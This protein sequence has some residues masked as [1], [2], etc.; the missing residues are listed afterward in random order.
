M[1]YFDL[2]VKK[3]DEPIHL[4]VDSTGLKVAG[5]GEWK[6]RTWGAEY[7]RKWIKLHIGLDARSGQIVSAVVTDSKG[8][9][10]GPPSL[11]TASQR[12]PKYARRSIAPSVAL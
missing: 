1:A 10:P 5:E 7:R 4:L 9:D 2:G 3:T 11:R 12:P 8:G 6:T